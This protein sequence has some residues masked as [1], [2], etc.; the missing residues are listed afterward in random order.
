[1]IGLNAA[2]SVMVAV[3]L[4][5]CLAVSSAFSTGGF[6][7]FAPLAGK[8]CLVAQHTSQQNFAAPG[9]LSRSSRV[10]LTGLRMGKQAAFGPFT[11]VVVAARNVIGE[12]RFNQIRGKVTV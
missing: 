7:S 8:S 5:A 11:P 6:G 4:L 9:G 10:A 2:S 12:K 3:L 1:M